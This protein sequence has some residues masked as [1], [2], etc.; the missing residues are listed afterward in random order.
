MT[1]DRPR[2]P[3]RR[4]GVCLRLR[5]STGASWWC[6]HPT[7]STEAMHLALTALTAENRIGATHRAVLV[8]DGA[9]WHTSGTLDIPEGI[10]PVVLPPSSPEVQPVERVWS[11]VDEPV[12]NRPF[13]DL[14]ELEAVLVA[15]CRT[16]RADRR[17]I[18]AHT[19][20][21]WWPR[22]HHPRNTS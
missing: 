16:L 13:A 14:D 1:D 18:K 9:G 11:L 10:D 2:P 8:L 21:H 22:G 3:S 19:R 12:A 6:L 20:F 4:M 15:R 17:T 7:V 5:P